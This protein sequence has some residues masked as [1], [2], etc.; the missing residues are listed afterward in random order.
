MREAAD[1]EDSVDKHPVTPGAVLPARELFGD[2]LLLLDR[3]NE[4]LEAYE[5]TLK[6]SPNRF[7]GLYGAGRAAELAGDLNKATSH[8]AKLMQITDGT[9]RIRPRIRQTKMFLSKN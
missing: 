5:A 4:A 2:M 9:D 7:N 8:Y 6:I 1:L 3:H